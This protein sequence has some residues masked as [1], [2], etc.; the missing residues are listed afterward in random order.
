MRP[1]NQL[2]DLRRKFIQVARRLRVLLEAIRALPPQERDRRVSYVAIEILNLWSEFCRAYYL[3]Y[4][5]GPTTRGGARLRAQN[6]TVRTLNDAIV[7]LWR[8]LNGRAPPGTTLRRRQEPKWYEARTLPTAAVFLRVTNDSEVVGAINLIART[9]QDFPVLRNFYA[10]RN[11]Q[12]A[13]SVI[14]MVPRYGM[15]QVRHPTE[16]ALTFL[17][18]RSEP[19]LG[20][21]I[22]D[23]EVVTGLLC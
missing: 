23:L 5:L 14:N 9:L 3:S 22:A 4:L 8:E 7:G 16:F 19:I 20:E 10:H 2:D 15:L 21:W 6:G 1:T 13:I 18:G 11:E 17:P 12:T